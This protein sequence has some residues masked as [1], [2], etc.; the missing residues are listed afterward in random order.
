[1][2]LRESRGRGQRRSLQPDMVKGFRGISDSVSW[3]I[4][5][6]KMSWASS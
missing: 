3:E 2:P 5:V 4:Q 1:M 6:R